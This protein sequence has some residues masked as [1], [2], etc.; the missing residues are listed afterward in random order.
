MLL[1]GDPPEHPSLLLL[2]ET[3]RP[4]TGETP[5]LSSCVTPQ[6]LRSTPDRGGNSTFFPQTTVHVYY[7]KSRHNPQINTVGSPE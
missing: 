4:L 6:G 7:G 2:Q 5:I 1:S 3:R